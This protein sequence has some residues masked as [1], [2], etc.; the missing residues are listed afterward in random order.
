VSDEGGAG[1]FNATR[2]EFVIVSGAA[3]KPLPIEWRFKAGEVSVTSD[4][5]MNRVRNLLYN[6]MVNPLADLPIKGVI[7]YQGESNAG[8]EEQARR[9]RDQFATLI[10]SWRTEIGGGRSGFPFLWVQLPNYG[11]TDSLPPLNAGWAMLRESQA[12]ALAEPQ[13]AQ[14]V[15]IDIGDAAD[16]HPR[17]K[18]D[19]AKRLALAARAVAYGE[20]I[21][22]RGPMYSGHD[23]SGNKFTVRFTDIQERLISRAV[24]DG[25]NMGDR[26]EGFAIAGEDGVFHWA[27]AKIVGKTSVVVWSDAVTKPVAVRYAWANGP[28]NPSLYNSVGLPAIP[29]RTDSR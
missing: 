12:A 26:V 20:K 24:K 7:W 27:Q 19:V 29:F 11:G 8:N 22:Y 28:V 17:N 23:V 18:Q 9:Y 14:A 13:T 4:G 25:A 5:R 21:P 3:R 15:T 10:K 1:G 16:L 6:A 2:E